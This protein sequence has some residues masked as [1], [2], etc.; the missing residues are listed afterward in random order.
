MARIARLTIIYLLIAYSHDKKWSHPTSEH[1]L[2]LFVVHDGSRLQV[3]RLEPIR[4]SNGFGLGWAG[5]DG[6]LLLLLLRTL[7]GL[8]LRLHL[9]LLLSHGLLSHSLNIFLD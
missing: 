3:L 9:H 6:L 2:S 1:V 8:H 4:K 7:L 5:L